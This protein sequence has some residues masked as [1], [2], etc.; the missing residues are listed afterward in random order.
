MDTSF[1]GAIEDLVKLK[2]RLAGSAAERE[3][4][5]VIARRLEAA[6]QTPVLEGFVEVTSA[7]L[8]FA[9]HLILASAGAAV[10]WRWPLL[11]LCLVLV[12]IGSA[13]MQL[14]GRGR[15]LRRLIP[16][17]A[18]YNVV[19]RRPAI[20]RRLGTLLV[21]AH[22]D[23]RRRG[24]KLTRRIIWPPFALAFLLAI[25]LLGRSL[26]I[27][28]G[29]LPLVEVF[30]G[31]ALGLGVLVALLHHRLPTRKVP[32]S[33]DSGI[34]A[35]EELSQALQARQL[36]HL[37]VAFVVAG[38]GEAHAGGL[39]ALLD[40]HRHEWAQED[41]F[42]VVLENLDRGQLVFGT[43]E[44]LLDPLHY[45]PT[46]PAV[47]ERVARQPAWRHVKSCVIDGFTGALVPTLA[48]MRTLVLSSVPRPGDAPEL[49]DSGIREAAAFGA[50][51]AWMLDRDI[52][53]LER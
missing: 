16:R 40:Q 42:V 15:G 47:A 22:L 7:P 8:N 31:L 49:P 19:V 27:A 41:T 23:L 20:G 11:G 48:G 10:G 24:F 50:E 12:A 44:R 18:S 30:S 43:G 38:C 28:P 39:R 17:G 14:R 46:L 37:E 4:I 33:G 51:L 9:L 2:Q 32:G 6:G 29:L 52:G 13:V 1:S 34:A 45:R 25:A 36:R 53:E 35:L 3:A 21:T 26:G 5:A